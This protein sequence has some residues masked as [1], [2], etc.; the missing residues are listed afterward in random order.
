[1]RV[2]LLSLSLLS[3]A[4][5]GCSPGGAAPLAAPAAP[6]AAELSAPAATIETPQTAPPATPATPASPPGAAPPPSAPPATVDLPTAEVFPESRPPAPAGLPP[7]AQGGAL[8]PLPNFNLP[9]E[10]WARQELARRGFRRE[11]GK[12]LVALDP[13]HGGLEVG[14]AQGRLA[15]KI[16]NLQIALH[17]RSL[18]EAEGFQV[19]L[20]RE[21]DQR[22][23]NLPESQSLSPNN[24][25]RADLQGRVDLANAAGAD[26]FVSIH[27]NGSSNPSEAGTEVWY[28]P[29][30][31]FGDKN[32]LLAREV[33]AGLVE[34]L[35]AAGYVTANRGLKNGSQFRL[36]RD[37]VFPLFVLGNPRTEPR[38][39][40]ATQMPGILGESLFLSNGYEASVLAQEHIQVA[41][42]RGYLRGITRYFALAGS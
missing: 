19:V 26:I 3:A 27:N 38:V 25:T 1:M 36:F 4:L 33:L 32:W 16:L 31:P 35:K 42:A 23:F 37:R 8:L 24:P 30:R 15:E 9:P 21:A 17:L 41:I 28:A 5:L 34:E 40:R 7:A 29:D 20:T 6:A 12:K 39:T 2:S 10:D 18:L 13:G 22:A 14:A 11:P